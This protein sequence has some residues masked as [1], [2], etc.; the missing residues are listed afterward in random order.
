MSSSKEKR[1]HYERGTKGS[2]SSHAH[3]SSRD[4]GVGSSSASDRAS[5]G[6]SPNDE[7]PFSHQQIENQRR[8]LS[9]V[10]EAL[11]A[12]YENIRQLEESLA[13]LNESLTESNKENRQLKREKMELM[14]KVDF[15][16]DELKDEKRLN[17]RVRRE[18]T[19]RTGASTASY[20]SHNERATP[21]RRD[22]FEARPPRHADEGSQ[23]SGWRSI[24]RESGYDRPPIVPQPPYNST[25]NP[26]T[27]ISERSAS[28]AYMPTTVT[29]APATV[30]YSTAPVFPTAPAPNNYPNDG[31]YHPYPL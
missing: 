19:P 14:N 11:D 13:R 31:R 29:Y 28:A 12:A 20:G 8:D 17:E 21:P 16:K 22:E 3:R 18:G 30:T 5:L 2:K 23:A 1:V 27:P 4:S 26:F 15:L 10:H 24:R 25:P 6:T 7:A 9:A